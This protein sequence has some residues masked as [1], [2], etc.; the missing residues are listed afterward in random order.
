MIIYLFVVENNAKK[1]E[2]LHK[3]IILLSIIIFV[4]TIRL[5]AY[6]V[7]NT[8]DITEKL[9]INDDG[10]SENKHAFPKE[11]EELINHMTYSARQVMKY[12][13]LELENMKSFMVLIRAVNR[14]NIRGY[15]LFYKKKNI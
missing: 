9:N 3:K 5:L 1:R 4:C 13:N 10:S 2:R 14:K 15:R 6:Q 11:A 8:T 7:G 12:K